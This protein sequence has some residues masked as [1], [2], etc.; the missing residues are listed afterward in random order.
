MLNTVGAEDRTFSEREQVFLLSWDDIATPGHMNVVGAE[1]ISCGAM[2]LTQ[3]SPLFDSLL[4]QRRFRTESV[5]RHDI[6]RH[7]QHLI[8]TVLFKNKYVVMAE[9]Y[10]QL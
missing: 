9:G 4:L 6:H 2:W 1:G 8:I 7:V 10:E 3:Y 5:V